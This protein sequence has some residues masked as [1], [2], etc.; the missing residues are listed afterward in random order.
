MLGVSDLSPAAAV[1]VATVM[2]LGTAS[3]LAHLR[4][5]RLAAVLKMGAASGYLALALVEGAAASAY[6][7]VLLMGLALCWLG[8]LLLIPE[9]KG[10]TFLGGLGS[11]LLGHVAYG[12]A[13]VVAGVSAPRV[14]AAGVPVLLVGLVI[15]RWL[16]AHG[17]PVTMRG[18][19]VAYV[20]AISAMVALA[21]GAA[22]VD[23]SP[24]VPAGAVAFM[25]SDVFVAR[26]RFVTASP[27]NTGLGLPLYFLAQALL[28][29]SA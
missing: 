15:L 27:W 9:G 13:F 26:E 2:T 7:R 14:A 1:L 23:A 28:A 29:L 12:V 5:P 22:G 6:G 19:V 16:W 25:A 18:P 20:V 4:R 3:A 10:P 17:L 21:W 24:V 11:F 8:D